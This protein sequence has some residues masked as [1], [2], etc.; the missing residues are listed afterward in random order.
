MAK[1]YVYL[2]K[3]WREESFCGRRRKAGFYL[4]A[5]RD[6][7]D[8]VSYAAG[9]LLGRASR[10]ANWTKERE[11]VEGLAESVSEALEDNSAVEEI[12]KHLTAF[13]SELHKG[14][15]YTDPD[16]SFECDEMEKLL[17]HLNIGF[18]PGHLEDK[19]P[20]SRLS[21]GQKSLLY[22]SLVLTGFPDCSERFLRAASEAAPILG[23]IN[24][25]TKQ[26]KRVRRM[27]L[28]LKALEDIT[29]QIVQ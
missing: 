28:Y 26:E 2:R 22:L 13:W 12:A 10:S 25:G 23:V 15:F 29:R 18:S 24:V 16:L 21:D 20:S 9:S 14:T 5:R 1:G 6:P 3:N 4:P 11:I 27:R 8:H 19:V 7:S 17:R